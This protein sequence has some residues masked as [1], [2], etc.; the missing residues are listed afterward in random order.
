VLAKL[1]LDEFDTLEEATEEAKRIVKGIAKAR[2]TKDEVVMTVSGKRKKT[3][4]SAAGS[5]GWGSELEQI[6]TTSQ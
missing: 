5:G 3:T 1:D 6:A 4:Q 2:A